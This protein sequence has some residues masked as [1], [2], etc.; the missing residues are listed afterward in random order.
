MNMSCVCMCEC[1]VHVHVQFRFEVYSRLH[2]YHYVKMSFVRKHLQ[3]VKK[4][5]KQENL[6]LPLYKT[7]LNVLVIILSS[8]FGISPI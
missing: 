8:A 1:V 5:K 3:N 2:Q 7:L 4:K 6:Y